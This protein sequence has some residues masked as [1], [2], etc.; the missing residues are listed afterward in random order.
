M[1]MGVAASQAERVPHMPAH[2]PARIKP[3]VT[4]GLLF[5]DYPFLDHFAELTVR[6]LCDA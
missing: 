3:G 6:Q 2:F 4:V 1:C 5:V